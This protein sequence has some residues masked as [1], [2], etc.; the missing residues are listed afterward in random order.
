MDDDEAAYMLA[1]NLD[2]VRKAKDALKDV[3]AGRGA[4][5]SQAEWTPVY[6]AVCRWERELAVIV[7][8]EE[9][10]RG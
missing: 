1:E 4:G 2:L 10:G 8:P 3:M 9:V 5:V 7:E 6:E